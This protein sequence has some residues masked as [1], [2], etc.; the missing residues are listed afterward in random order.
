MGFLEG[1]IK[2]PKTSK[3]T[4]VIQRTYNEPQKPLANQ[5]EK[6]PPNPYLLEQYSTSRDVIYCA[7]LMRRMYSLDLSI[8]AMEDSAPEDIPSREAMK[9]SANALLGEIRDV[10]EA[11]QRDIQGGY[12][13]A[14]K[15][16]ERNLIDEISRAVLECP[17]ERYFVPTDA[18]PAGTRKLGKQRGPSAMGN[19]TNTG[20]GNGHARASIALPELHGD[21]RPVVELEAQSLRSSRRAQIFR[22]LRNPLENPSTLRTTQAT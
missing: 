1:L 3:L 4:P 19:S 10:V 21:T 17:A 7:Q 15:P 13:G 20:G 6:P 14:W 22:S 5:P 9:T 2:R 12:G 11:W 18:R 8:W 16:E